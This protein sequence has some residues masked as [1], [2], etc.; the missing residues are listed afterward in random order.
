MVLKES[1]IDGDDISYAAPAFGPSEQAI[2]SFHFNARGTRHF[3][4]ITQD[5][6]GRPFAVVIDGKVI[7]APVIREP[8]VNG[9][10]QISGN[11][12]LEEANSVAM[13]L[14]SGTLPGRLSVVEQQ[15][16]ESSGHAGTQ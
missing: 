9:S 14:L 13:L 3:A 6:V 2:V 11:L 15:V 8:I 4:H 12:T 1:V 10:G 16:V 7:S 5:K